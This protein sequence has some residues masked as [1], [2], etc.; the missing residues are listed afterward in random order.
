MNLQFKGAGGSRL[1]FVR[2]RAETIVKR[3][4]KIVRWKKARKTY[5]WL[6]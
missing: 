5:T 3:Y 4:G 1:F 2:F 6:G